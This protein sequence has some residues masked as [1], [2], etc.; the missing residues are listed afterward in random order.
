MENCYD[1]ENLEVKLVM[2]I[3][4]VVSVLQTRVMT[5]VN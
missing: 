1:K 4:S 3:H 2:N 5:G